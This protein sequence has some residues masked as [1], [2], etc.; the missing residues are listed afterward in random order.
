MAKS[1][2]DVLAENIARYMEANPEL[3]T[4]ARLAARSGVDQKTISNY[5]NPQRRLA[6]AA[7]RPG[8]AK[9][10]EVEKIAAAFGLEAWELIKPLKSRVRR[11][12]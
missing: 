3:G 8:S 10:S 7:G 6:T 9:L 5:L 11:E 12:P 2:N 4:Q 1:V